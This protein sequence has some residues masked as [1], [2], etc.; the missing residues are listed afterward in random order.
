MKKPLRC[1]L[2][3]HTWRTRRNE[4]GQRYQLCL[5]CGITR[6]KLTLNDFGGG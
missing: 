2:R 3:V 1:V 6:D 5:G 4:E